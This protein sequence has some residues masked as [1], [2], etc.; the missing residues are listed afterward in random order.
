MA[1]MNPMTCLRSLILLLALSAPGLAA[2]A[3]EAPSLDALLRHPGNYSQNCDAR[4]SSYPAPIPGFK[5]IL[6]GEASFSEKNS[7]LIKKH[8]AALIPAIAAKLEAIDLKQ[9]PTEQSPDPA[10][11]KEEQD[12]A[13]VGA[14]PAVFSTLL[15]TL[16][17]QLDATEVF[18]QLLAFEE[19]H[20]AMLLAAEQDAAAPLPQAD[21]VEGAGVGAGNLLKEDEEYGKLTPERQAGVD[22]K[23]A[24]FHAQTLHRDI[25]AVFVRAMRKQGYG[26]MLSSDLEKTYG[27][28]LKA[29][30]SKN[31]DFNKYQSTTDI[32]EADRDSIKFD[33]IHKVAYLAWDPVEIPYSE[34]TR[35]AILDLT[36]GYLASLK[37]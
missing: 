15:L 23:T 10:I 34:A 16:I 3:P 6:H 5:T 14:D 13:P 22:R 31:E 19:K 37:K 36:K 28:L 11:P 1:K 27:R 21:G 35:S 12:V 24:V 17:E 9:K 20:H 4:L 25:L 2:P 7:D 18:P 8:R 32:P 29:K 26:P 33:P 30:W